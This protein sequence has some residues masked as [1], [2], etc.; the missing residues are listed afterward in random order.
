MRKRIRMLAAALAVALLLTVPAFAADDTQTEPGVY[1]VTVES[2]Y[3]LELQTADGNKAESCLAVVGGTTS[4]LYTGAVK[5]TLGFTGNTGEQYVVFLLQGSEVVP[6][7]SNIRYIDQ[8]E[9]GAISFTV[10]PSELTTPG[11]YGVYVSSTNQAYTEVAS[12]QVTNSWEKAPYILGD[13]DM[14]QSVTSAD[15]S[16]V[17]Q[18][19]VRLITLSDDQLASA[20]VSGSNSVTSND[21]AL[22]LQYA[23]KL[24]DKFPVE[25]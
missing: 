12:F 25:G 24:I 15:A 13:V 20:S 10:Y 7:Q 8:K 19:V 21:A 5:F 1:N 4:T 3:T 2:G 11:D 18:Y 23:A 22:I 14:D 6:T 9:G 16:Q 17:L